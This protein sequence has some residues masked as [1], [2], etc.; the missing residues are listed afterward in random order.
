MIPKSKHITSAIITFKSVNMR[1]LK[2]H[3]DFIKIALKVGR[4]L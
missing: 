4:S 1:D 2:T 3:I